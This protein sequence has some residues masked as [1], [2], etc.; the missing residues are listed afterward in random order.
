MN[1][2]YLP[3][4]AT[5]PILPALPAWLAFA[6]GN[7]FHVRPKNGLDTNTGKSTV[8]AFKT[9]AAAKATAT[10]GQNDIVLFYGEGNASADCTDYQTAA[11]DWSKDMVHLIGVNSG[12]SMNPRA[13]IAPIA[14]YASAAPIFT[15]SGNGC[16]VA[17]LSV[18]MGVADTTPLGSMA[19]TGQRNRFDRVHALGMGAATNDIAGAYSLLLSGAE[20]CEFHECTF[21]S[22]RVGG[23]AQ[24]NSVL[25]FANLAKNIVFDACK[26]RLVSTSATNRVFVRAPTGSL[27]GSVAFVN[28]CVGINSQSRNVAGLELTYAMIVAA[29]AGGDIFI[30]PDSVF[31]AA[32]VNSTNSGNVYGAAA[33]TSGFAVPITQ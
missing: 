2:P 12:V 22:D 19:V 24:A 25:K 10:A 31:Q 6:Q 18:Y 26:F 20:E 5:I 8:Q 33:A 28:G 15:V 7:I 21:G 9:L 32:D 14:G 23:G 3:R 29:D 1:T 16:Y 17:N 4:V 11:F 30:S 13:R 27:D